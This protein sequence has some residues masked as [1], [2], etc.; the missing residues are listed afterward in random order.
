MARRHRAITLSAGQRVI[1]PWHINNLNGH[2]NRLKSWLR[3]FKGAACS[4][5]PHDLGWFRAPERF[6]PALLAPQAL[7]GPAIGIIRQ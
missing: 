2:P 3:R 5:L 4:D 6:K 7:L 1:G